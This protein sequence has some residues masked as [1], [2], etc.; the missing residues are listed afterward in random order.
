MIICPDC[1]N[2]V[3][4]NKFCKNCGAY[5]A[6]IEKPH[7]K[8]IESDEVEEIAGENVPAVVEREIVPSQ[9]FNYCYN[10]GFELTGDF[11]F[12][13]NCGNSLKTI[14]KSSNVSAD[15]EK[16]MLL[17]IIL[18]VLLPGLGQIYLGLDNKGAKFL[19]AYVV[20]AI[21]ILILIGFLLCAIIWIWALVDTIQS[22]NTLNRGEEV[23]DKLF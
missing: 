14:V 12:C 9:K 2:E 16:N 15:S 21:L 17:A 19:I 5:I 23:T 4:Q 8:A 18:S 3:P 7:V 6:N 13:P 10:C 11:N 22:T 20:S 1:G